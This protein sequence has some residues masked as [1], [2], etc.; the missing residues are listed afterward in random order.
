MLRRRLDLFSPQVR[1]KLCPEASRKARGLPAFDYDKHVWNESVSRTYAADYLKILRE[2]LKK[3]LQ[4]SPSAAELYAAYNMGMSSFASCADSY[5]QRLTELK[6][7]WL[8]A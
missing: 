7:I 4:R 3:R 5:S 1:H 2:Q 6:C 8:A